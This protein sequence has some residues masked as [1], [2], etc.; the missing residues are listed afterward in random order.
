MISIHTQN[1]ETSKWRLR[2]GRTNIQDTNANSLH[3]S[4]QFDDLKHFQ[5]PFYL[6]SFLGVLTSTCIQNS[7]C[8][9]S[10]WLPVPKSRYR[11]PAKSQKNRNWQHVWHSL[12]LLIFADTRKTVCT[13]CSDFQRIKSHFNQYLRQQNTLFST[14]N[15]ALRL[16]SFP[17]FFFPLHMV[18]TYHFLSQRFTYSGLTAAIWNLQSWFG[19]GTA[20]V[21]DHYQG[22]T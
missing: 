21:W 6:N 20:A 9:F 19:F 10:K 16:T 1:E 17:I 11:V 13:L 8:K 15:W 2:I 14:L 7:T 3:F 5:K 4:N 12:C 18:L 22:S